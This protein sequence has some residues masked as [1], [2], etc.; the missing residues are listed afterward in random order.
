MYVNQ[1]DDIIDKILDKLYLEGLA[2]DVTFRTIVENKKINYV[3]YRDK[4]NQFIQQF[5][6]SID[7]TNIQK[8]INNKENLIKIL[9]IIKRYITYYYF[10]SLAYYYT[11]TIRDFRNNLIQYSKLQETSTFIIKNFF[12]TE[13]N[14]QIITFF[15]IIKDV[16]NIITM[17]DLQKKTLNPLEIKDALKFLSS[18]GKYYI[19]N[20]LLTIVQ[21]GDQS[22]VEVNV[23]NLI[24]TIVFGEI[25]MNQ[26]RN[27]V[28]EIVNDIEESKHEYTFID[29]VVTSDDVSDLE[30]FKQIFVGEEKIETLSLDLFELVNETN[31]IPSILSIDT[32]NNNLIELTTITPI[33]DDFIRYHRDSE[34]L[35]SENEK[36]FIIPPVNTNNAK[37]IQL[38][39]LYQQ[40]KKKENTKA[41]LIVNKIDAI[42]DYY[43]ENVKNNEEL[44]KDIKKYFQGPLSYRKAVLHNYLDELRVLNKILNQGKRAI[45]GNEY[46][47]ELKYAISHAYF[48]FK[49]FQ[50]YGTSFSLTSDLPINMLRY[51]N[52][53]YQSQMPKLELDIHTAVSDSLV[54]LVGLAIRPVNRNPIQCIR[55]ENLVD[56]RGLDITYLKNGKVVTKK[57]DNGYNAFLKIIKHFYIDTI[58][59]SNNKN[60]ELYNDFEEITKMNPEIS[61]K[62]IYWIYDVNKDVYEMETYEDLKSYNF[63][64]TIRFMNSKIYE[65]IIMFLNKKLINLIR[66][67]NNLP[68][69][70][71]EWLVEI[72]SIVNKLF[73]TQDEKRT[74]I[75]KEFLK[76]KV[77]IESKIPIISDK[78]RIEMPVYVPIFDKITF[79]IEIDTTNPLN[80]H[81]YVNFEIYTKTEDSIISTTE[82]RCQHENEWNEIQKFKKENLNKYNTEVIQFI[83]KFAI[84]T[85]DLDYICRV[86]GQILPLKQHVQDGKYDNNSQKFITA[87][88]P[89]DIPLKDVKE[90]TKYKKIIKYLD[91]LINRISLIT[92]TNMLTGQSMNVK[93]KRKAL[94]KNI[95]DLIIK[96]NFVNLRKKQNSDERAD[97][98]SK[99]FNVNKD[100]DDIFFF[101]IDN[102]IF[103]FSITGTEINASVN[104]LKL[105]NILLYFML[106]FL[107]ELNGAQITMMFS[108]KIA[109][110]YV[111]LNPKYGVK[112]FDNLLIKRNIND[113]ET[114]EIIKYPVL[115]YLIFV[116]AYFLIKYEL[117]FY[118]AAKTKK[119]N[120]VIARIIINSFVDLFNSIIMDAGKMPNDYIYLLTTSKIYSQLNNTFRNN[121]IINVLKRNHIKYA[122]KAIDNVPVVPQE[123]EIK[124]NLIKEPVRIIRRPRK[125]PSFKLT[126][127]IQYDRPDQILYKTFEYN[128]DVTN[129][130][131]GS[132]HFWTNANKNIECIFCHEKGNTVTG[133]INRTDESY[134][135]NLNKIANRRCLQGTVHN[136]VG[137]E[138][139]FI[140]TICKRKK[141]E[142][143]TMADSNDLI[144]SLNKKEKT[145]VDSILNK[146]HNQIKESYTKEELDILS[147]NLDRIENENIQKFL[148]KIE[149]QR[150]E[151]QENETRIEKIVKDLVSNY[152]KEN[153]NKIFGQIYLSI[154]KL[155][156]ELE[157]LIGADNNLD[158]DKYPVYLRDNVYVID[159]SYDG[160][161]FVEPII[162]MQ[163]DN[164]IFFKSNHPFFKTDV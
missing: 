98:F 79:K 113:T 127:G 78:D 164:R 71:I 160:S 102:N 24:K 82:T 69:F 110:I 105:N 13:N 77:N 141:A 51:D 151:T 37:N 128:N 70:K 158:I 161:S 28:F 159:H 100:L 12:D 134:Y 57:T 131:Y 163:K 3:E 58:K 140:C 114:V 4:I 47:L 40:R 72:F 65:K 152:H 35:D 60:I 138:G 135:Y 162:L 36:S 121:D 90:Y 16:V 84:E 118:P 11:G 32:K 83:E 68:I 146:F 95:L 120:P 155:I 20:Y 109:N 49:D 133:E 96:H 156:K 117:W 107:T 9:D 8:I 88:V 81:E 21:K 31:R 143:Y 7:I 87:Y 145:I 55:K 139:E 73:L 26:E 147:K 66:T 34:K 123:E 154:D 45:E 108:D 52:I 44:K 103:D 144:T 122:E 101:E 27:F 29:I 86:C 46:F 42:S 22:I 54:N 126:S 112:L 43:S 74:L 18:F 63:Q 25:Y 15:K 75:I 99:K 5:M 94:V 30:S 115:C 111:Y 59:F 80:P 53:E 48:N 125:I 33:I 92:G 97:F 56:I 85:T 129:C 61:D 23:H 142:I 10:L 17:T 132:Y 104:R 150:R 14:Y 38:A 62:V 1:I 50:N 119:F 19:D 157:T 39:L 89:L 153:G 137:K 93:Q 2:K 130:V 116:M 149:E 124:I 91:G 64:E 41:Q 6:N 67:N 148:E 106:I 76:R 136:F